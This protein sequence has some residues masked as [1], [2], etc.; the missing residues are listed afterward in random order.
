MWQFFGEI[1]LA[2]IPANLILSPISTVYMS[3]SAIGLIIGWIP[4]LGTVV[5][6]MI[7]IV[8]NVI[9]WGADVFANMRGA[10]ISLRYPFVMP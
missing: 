1:S 9:V 10:V 6:W 7:G 4:Y 3:L 2:A 5:S 8:G